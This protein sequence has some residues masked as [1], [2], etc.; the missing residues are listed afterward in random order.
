MPVGVFLD[1]DLES[2]NILCDAIR[3]IQDPLG[4]KARMI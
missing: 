2:P 1:H 3:A 4:V